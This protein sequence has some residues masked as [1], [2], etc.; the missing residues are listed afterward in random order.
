MESHVTSVGLTPMLVATVGLT[1]PNAVLLTRSGHV[2]RTTSSTVGQYAPASGGFF[3]TG[4][5]STY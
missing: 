1:S 5:L 4:A 3:G 2:A